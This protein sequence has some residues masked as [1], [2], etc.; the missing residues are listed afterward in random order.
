[1]NVISFEAAG[2]DIA[3]RTQSGIVETI[4]PCRQLD[5]YIEFHNVQ[6][7]F[8]YAYLLGA[9]GEVGAFTG[10]KLFLKDFI[11]RYKRLGFSVMDE[12][13]G[14]NT[15]KYCGYLLADGQLCECAV[16]ICHEGDM[17]FV[18]ED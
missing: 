10:E 13:Y 7:D 6:W 4:A 14:C 18:S 15:T 16:E 12:A 17:V 3:M 1:M 8:S 9:A 2:N 5:G 11:E